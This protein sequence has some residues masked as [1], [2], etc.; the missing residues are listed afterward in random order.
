MK[1][2]MMWAYL[3]HLGVRM[4]EDGGINALKDYEEESF[5]NDEIW[6][7]ITDF[8]PS[9]GF[10]TIV[11]DVGEAMQYESHPEIAGEGAWSKDK[12]KKELDRLR[13]IGLT[14]I[15]K[16]NFSKNHD[17]WLGKYHFMI[18]TPQYY[19]VCEDVIREVYEVFD[20]PEYFQLGMDEEVAAWMGGKRVRMQRNSDLWWHDSYFLFD[21]CDKLGTRPWVWS[22]PMWHKKEE[23][24]EK[25]P[26]S[27]VQSNWYYH[28]F[29]FT[30]YGA[31]GRESYKDLDLAGFEQVPTC[32]GIWY[33]KSADSTLETLKK[34]LNPDRLIGYMEAPWF[35]TYKRN[36]YSLLDTAYRFGLAKK[37]HYPEYCR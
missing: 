37:K 20:S 17:T 21:I 10:N 6:R 34:T 12:L 27:V 4:W 5:T 32:S 22:D 9:Q 8:L 25:M 26:K 19:K 15:P 28:S 18:S 23:Y 30:E 36:Y 14:P 31:A 33:A 35:M 7:E 24:L 16:L 2:K 29:N 1:D 3:I 13:S 11:I